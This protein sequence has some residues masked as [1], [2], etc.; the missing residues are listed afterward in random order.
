LGSRNVAIS[1]TPPTPRPTHFRATGIA[2]GIR[3]GERAR[4]GAPRVVRA[5]GARK[6]VVG[7][8]VSSDEPSG[9]R[10]AY[11]TVTF[12]EWS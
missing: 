2:R 5:R 7:E 8:E 1:S 12:L 4:A 10:T 3:R 6:V 11:S 9:A